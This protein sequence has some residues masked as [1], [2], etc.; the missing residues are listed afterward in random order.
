MPRIYLER[1][2]MDDELRR[3]FDM[4]DGE[5]QA[6]GG[7][8]ECNPPLDVRESAASIDIVMDLPGVP[9]EAVQIVFARGT[10]LIAGTKRP[11]SCGHADAAFHMAERTFGRFA[12]V[13]RL[14]GAVDAGRARATM[15]AG[16]L[17][18]TF[19][20]IEDRRGRQIRIAVGTD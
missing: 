11:A 8:G 17:R 3:L 1:R 15:T 20:R 6:G 2:E 7:T 10:A 4:L 18:I 9:L 5:A 14:A 12:R 13:V 19:P 16:E